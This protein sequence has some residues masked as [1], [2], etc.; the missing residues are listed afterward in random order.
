MTGEV[1][2]RSFPVSGKADLTLSNIS[3]TVTLQAGETSEIVVKASKHP[4]WGNG[5]RTKIEMS[6]DKDGRVN[7]ATRHEDG[8]LG[9]FSFSTPCKVVYEV[10]L[11][12]ECTLQIS[13][14]S[15]DIEAH[16]LQGEL[17]FST[18]SGKLTLEKLS[19]S[20]HIS[21]VSGDLEGQ[22]LQGEL[23]LKTVSGD[24]LLN[25]I[26]ATSVEATTVSGNVHLQ[27][28]L[29]EGSY[30]LKSVSGDAR[31][32]LPEGAAFRAKLRS[33]SGDLRVTFPDARRTKTTGLTTVE[34]GSGGPLIVLKSIS[35]DL[36]I[37]RAG[38]ETLAA[39]AESKAQPETDDA[40]T[41]Q[42]G[43]SAERMAVLERIANGELSVDEGLQV[44][45]SE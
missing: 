41:A 39:E 17:K 11:P 37:Q 12:P 35:G 29:V 34:V 23:H 40:E 38:D 22:D 27:T 31:L 26:A 42:N 15:S 4:Q 10:R 13:G 19:G 20:I 6:Q 14:V 30:A 3:G 9:I 5:S 8:L 2:E 43:T 44:L 21:S 7:A 45:K 18:V 32:T 16:G 24:L 36:R 33:I 25:R 28:E 1:I